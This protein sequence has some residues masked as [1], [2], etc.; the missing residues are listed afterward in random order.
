VLPNPVAMRRQVAEELTFMDTATRTH[1]WRGGKIIPG[2][3]HNVDEVLGVSISVAVRAWHWLIPVNPAARR[4]IT[5]AVLE[6]LDRHALTIIIYEP[7]NWHFPTCPGRAG[8]V[9]RLVRS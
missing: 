3:M 8:L 4:S 7:G 5:P 9:I 2:S 1:H 6:R